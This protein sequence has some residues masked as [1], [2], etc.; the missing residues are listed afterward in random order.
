MEKKADYIRKLNIRGTRN[1]K[2]EARSK[3]GSGLLSMHFGHRDTFTMS[4]NAD[5]TVILGNF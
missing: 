4:H 1:P 2:I 5:H 3:N